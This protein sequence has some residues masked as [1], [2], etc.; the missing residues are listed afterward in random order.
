MAHDSTGENVDEGDWVC[1]AWPR[2]HRLCSLDPGCYPRWH[3]ALL[4]VPVRARPPKTEQ[5]TRT[6]EPSAEGASPVPRGY[7]ETNGGCLPE[8]V[9]EEGPAQP[10]TFASL[11]ARVS[12]CSYIP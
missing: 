10:I 9:F 2:A 11:R 6:S 1:S 12:T 5:L 3:R 7:L 8:A 4:P